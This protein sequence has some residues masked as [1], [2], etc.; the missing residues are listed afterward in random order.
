MKTAAAL[1]ALWILAP[2]EAWA[3]GTVGATPFNFL[4]SDAN[5]RPAALGGAYAAAA[6]DANAL[7]YNPAGLADMRGNEVTLEH[8]ELFQG[9]TQE[10]A[11]AALEQ[12][13]GVMANT[14]SF[15]QIQRTTISDPTGSGLGS[16]GI[17]DIAA[18]VGYGRSFHNGILSLGLAAK[19]ISETIDAVTAQS[20]AV[21]LGALADLS[22]FG[23]PLKAAFVVQNM[24]AAAKF[25]SEREDLP[26][27]FK[28]GLAYQPMRPGLVLF[29]VNAPKTGSPTISAGGEYVVLGVL[30]LRLGYNGRNEA[31][32]GLTVGGGITWREFSADYAFVPFGDLGDSSRFSLSFR[33]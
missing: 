22:P 12:G 15:G 2:P 7:L 26:L 17:R 9:I 21:D 1:L 16:F 10:Y 4:F 5:A 3:G 28:A 27:N 14:L 25:Q 32:S 6:T 18:S 24:G 23:L 31:G 33:W 8:A 13:F 30:A 20:G 29:D 19:Y 11:A